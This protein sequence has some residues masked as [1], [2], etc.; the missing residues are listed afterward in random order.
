ML[1]KRDILKAAIDH[2]KNNYL[3][4][5]LATIEQTK[6]QR[7]ETYIKNAAPQYRPLLKYKAA[8]LQEIP[9]KALQDGSIDLELY[10][11]SAKIELEL[12][13]KGQKFLSRQLTDIKDLPRYKAEY[14]QY[15]EQEND[16]GKAKLAQYIAHRKIVLTLLSNSLERGD[17]G[18]YSLEESVHG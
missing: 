17:D 14:N 13:Q 5:Y 18:K 1:S 12:K 2:L 6:Q 10:K 15:I 8:S 16:L 7:I 9:L 4:P 11:L 3:K